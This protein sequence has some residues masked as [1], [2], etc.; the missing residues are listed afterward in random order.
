MAHTQAAPVTTAT[1]YDY[2]IGMNAVLAE[3]GQRL[4]SIEAK[5][6][7]LIA[8]VRAGFAQLGAAS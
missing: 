8:E 7:G 5:L 2:M 1:V 4:D 3:H 6:D